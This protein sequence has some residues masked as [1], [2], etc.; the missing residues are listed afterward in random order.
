MA[1]LSST[2]PLGKVTD[3][4]ATYTPSV[5]H[6]MDR[7][8]ARAKAGV[9][10][11]S[12]MLGEDLWTGYEFSWLD[13]QGKPEVAGIR[14]RVPCQSSAIVESKS[15]KLYLG[16]FAM[17]KFENRASVLKTLDKD[18]TLAFR[19]PVTVE[20]LALP[21]LTGAVQQLSG[22]CLD[23]LDIWTDTY[24]RD[25]ALLTLDDAGN[26]DLVVHESFHT[27]LF[28][29]LCPVTGQPD[30]ASVGIEYQGAPIAQE[31]L[32]R[33]LVSYRT[34]QAFHETTVEQIFED[35]QERCRP[36]KL[37]VFGCFQRRGGL[38]INPYRANFA[39][40]APLTRLPRQ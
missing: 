5:L 22:T 4:P 1:T 25:P 15:L 27:H 36:D 13:M 19:S 11:A 16:S 26:A 40:E 2:G 23:D 34:H 12:A 39:G 10:Q 21:Q 38:D 35:L 28:R 29:S 18:L 7:K 37:A 9:T 20:L 3:A 31:A 24:E 33:Y 8:I 32:L 14:L 17:T 30:W 6:S